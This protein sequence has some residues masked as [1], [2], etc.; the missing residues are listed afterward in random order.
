LDLP[1]SRF[2][3]FGCV[4]T[5]KDSAISHLVSAD[6]TV[7]V[8]DPYRLLSTPQIA[9]V[10]PTLIAQ[11]SSLYVVVNGQL[12]PRTTETDLTAMIQK[13]LADI[14]PKTDTPPTSPLIHFVQAEKALHALDALAA[15]L[16][17]TASSQSRA[18]D[19]FQNEF[20]SSQVG[21]LQ[22]QLLSHTSANPQPQLNTSRNTLR[23]ALEYVSDTITS[24]HQATRHATHTVSE[25]RHQ[26]A[27]ASRKARHLSVVNRGIE[28]GIVEGGVDQEMEETKRDLDAG[29]RGRWSWLSLVGKLRVDDVGGEVGGYIERSFGRDLEKQVRSLVCLI[30]LIAEPGSRLYSKQGNW[31]I[32]R[33]PYP[34]KQILLSGNYLRLHIGQIVHHPSLTPSHPTYF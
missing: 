32:C 7:L 22:S 6:I 19:T 26:A 24:D 15:G 5:Q 21:K 2:R 28:S 10:L 27:Q 29:F 30:I 20:L 11:S 3:S 23:L 34:H 1:G 9:S 8:L 31:H 33:L 14:Q 16:E 12:P 4:A 18:F 17:H 13:Q 25:L